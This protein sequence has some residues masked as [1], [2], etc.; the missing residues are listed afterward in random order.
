MLLLPLDSPGFFVL[1]VH[2]P[3]ATLGGV[4]VARHVDG[5]ALYAYAGDS[6]G[7]LWRFDLT[8]DLPWSQAKA[9]KPLFTATRADGTPQAISVAP[10]VMFGPG[11]GYLVAFGSSGDGA[12]T[13]Y[14]FHDRLAG[15]RNAGR[16]DLVRRRAQRDGDGLRIEGRALDYGEHAGWYLDLACGAGERMAGLEASSG[17]LIASTSVESA[18]GCS[19]ALAPLTG[20]APGPGLTGKRTDGAAASVA[21]LFAVGPAEVVASSPLGKTQLLTYRLGRRDGDGKLQVLQ[22]LRVER[23]SGRLSWRELPHWRAL[24]RSSKEKP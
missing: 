22:E 5:R 11:G 14:A 2:S 24:H 10:A 1:E 19:Y 17:L 21:E 23:R 8:G 12:N 16:D 9:R 13:L 7:R 4:A 18:D 20:M 15:P 6:A 3:G